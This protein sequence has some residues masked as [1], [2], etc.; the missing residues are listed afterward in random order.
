MHFSGFSENDF[1]HGPTVNDAE[2]DACQA[3]LSISQLIKFNIKKDT[4]R[5]A[6]SVTHHT[7]ERETP[8][9]IYISLLIHSCTRNKT[10]IDKLYQLGICVS[11][12]RFLRLS[13]D[14]VNA[15]CQ[16]YTEKQVVCPPELKE[17][18]F[19]TATVDNI[20]Y[21]P[22]STTASGSFH[23]TG[24]SLFQHQ[25]NEDGNHVLNELGN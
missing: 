11:Y 16:C 13:S 21:N 12:D 17:R 19:T 15:V 18:L 5:V 14:L 20:D 8:L 9:P 1:L 2:V 6:S 22:S 25:C 3:A 23:G 24:I 10:I 7:T 4:P